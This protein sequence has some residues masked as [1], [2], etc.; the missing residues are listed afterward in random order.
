YLTGDSEFV[1]D[2]EQAA[3]VRGHLFYGDPPLREHKQGKRQRLKK[4]ITA[5][6]EKSS[7]QIVMNNR[8]RQ[9]QSPGCRNSALN[10]QALFPDTWNDIRYRD[11][12]QRADY[13]HVVVW[14]ESD[15]RLMEQ[16]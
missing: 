8:S 5:K 7:V 13:K 12:K 3:F 10:K 6:V 1:F 16:N 4:G 9:N 11:G 15:R 2:G 14:H